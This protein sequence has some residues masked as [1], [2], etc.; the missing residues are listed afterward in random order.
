MLGNFSGAVDLGLILVFLIFFITTFSRLSLAWM[1]PAELQTIPLCIFCL[2]G[3]FVFLQP[4]CQLLPSILPSQEAWDT[5]VESHRGS[6]SA[7]SKVVTIFL[8]P[9]GRL[10]HSLSYFRHSSAASGTLCMGRV[11]SE[12]TG[13]SW[14]CVRAW[15]A[16]WISSYSQSVMGNA[17]T[18]MAILFSEVILLHWQYGRHIPEAKKKALA[19]F[20]WWMLNIF[21]KKIR[22]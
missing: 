14:T 15:F 17:S 5:A 12:V 6:F 2:S 18:F 21:L 19:S 16:T 8:H 20:C 4:G 13:L 9:L 22:S 3:L 11:F 10:P 7:Y 1:V